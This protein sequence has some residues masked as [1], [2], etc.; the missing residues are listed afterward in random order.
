MGVMNGSSSETQ[1]VAITSGYIATLQF[2]VTVVASCMYL[3]AI[4]GLLDNSAHIDSYVAYTMSICIYN[5]GEWLG[6]ELKLQ[7]LN[8]F[9]QKTVQ[10][11]ETRFLMQI[12]CGGS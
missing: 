5:N 2:K 7:A 6:W 1:H 10:P 3:H 12:Y 8:T 9:C 4:V 11:Y